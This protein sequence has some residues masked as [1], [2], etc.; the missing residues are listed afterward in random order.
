MN[1]KAKI[2][3]LPR[4]KLANLPTPF[5][6]MNRLSKALNGPR[7]FIKRDDLTGPVFGGNKA[8]KLEFV[9]ADALEKGADVIVAPGSLQSN[10]ARTVAI[11]ARKLGVKAVLVLRGEKPQSYDGNLLIDKLFGAEIRFVQAKQHEMKS[12]LKDIMEE[13]REK[14]YNPYY[15]PPSSPLGAVGYVNAFQE[16]ID[17]A[18]SLG[19]KIDYIVHAA[20]S[21]ATQA[22]LL[23]GS[24]AFNVKTRVIG[25]SVEPDNHQLVKTT[26]N[27]AKECARILDLNVSFS[28][29]DVEILYDYVGEGYG[30]LTQE[31]KETIKIVAQ[32]EGILLD[33]VYTGKAMTGLISMIKEGYFEK[34][35]NVIFIH[36]GGIPA[37]FVYKDKLV[38]LNI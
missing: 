22:G 26:L 27:L 12:I 15:A 21:G 13:F 7:M 30:I 8:C 1:L 34:D 35:D 9:M 28:P 31:I 4:V 33:P 10:H 19:V 6:E 17:Q 36:T 14:G 25:I 16:L 23:V 37:I 5:E 2:N 29:S 3:N 11:V 38:S 18:E 24:K 32:T 20:G